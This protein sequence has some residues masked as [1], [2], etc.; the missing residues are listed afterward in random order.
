[1]VLVRWWATVRS[2]PVQHWRGLTQDNRYRA[3]IF[4]PSESTQV[5]RKDGHRG[6][7]SSFARE[8]PLHNRQHITP[9]HNN[10]C[11][12]I[13]WRA[14]RHLGCLLAQG[15]M[16]GPRSAIFRRV[17]VHEEALCALLPPNRGAGVGRQ[18]RGMSEPADVEVAVK[19]CG[20]GGHVAWVRG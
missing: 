16:A 19:L 7:P 13:Q 9:L 18:M 3:V 14:Y 20:E 17:F 4:R 6:R 11:T 5:S 12:A 10:A 1:M 8:I 15:E 2:L